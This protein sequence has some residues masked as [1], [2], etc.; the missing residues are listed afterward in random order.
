MEWKKAGRCDCWSSSAASPGEENEA[1][2]CRHSRSRSIRR[3]MQCEINRSSSSSKEMSGILRAMNNWVNA[4]L[5]SLLLASSHDV[6]VPRN[7]KRIEV[8]RLAIIWDFRT[9]RRKLGFFWNLT[10]RGSPCNGAQAETRQKP[11]GRGWDV[12][13]KGTQ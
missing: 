2:V 6:R 5:S 1:V 7:R 12:F 3:G 13:C 9:G 11:P 8:F 4:V 10:H